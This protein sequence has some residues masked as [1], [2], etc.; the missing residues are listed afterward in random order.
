MKGEVTRFS[1]HAAEVRIEAGVAD[2]VKEDNL[3]AD[4]HVVENIDQNGQPIQGEGE[5][6]RRGKTSGLAGESAIVANQGHA[7]QNGES[8]SGQEID[9]HLAR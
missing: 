9:G 3:V 6:E 1:D 4:Q 2:H 8:E 5:D 7:E